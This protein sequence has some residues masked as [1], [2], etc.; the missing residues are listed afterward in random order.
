MSHLVISRP[1][2]IAACRII[3]SYNR[4]MHVAMTLHTATPL[5]YITMED[6]N[7]SHTLTFQE[8]VFFSTKC[9]LA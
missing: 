8:Y 6:P 9:R 4:H 5:A 1:Q 7:V 2:R 3:L